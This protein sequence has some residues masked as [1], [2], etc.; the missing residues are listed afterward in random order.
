MSQGTVSIYG[1]PLRAYN[2]D[3]QKCAGEAYYPDD[4]FRR[5]ILPF[6]ILQYL[7]QA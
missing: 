4:K 7:T 6:F 2:A 5:H 3:C 1:H